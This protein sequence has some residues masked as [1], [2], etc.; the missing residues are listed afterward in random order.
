MDDTIITREGLRRLSDELER[1]KTE[2]R[3]SIAERLARAVASEANRDEN[4]ELLEAR[5]EQGLLE[6]RIAVLEE[7]LRSAL[8]VE[9]Q[10]GNGR[11]DVGERVRIR[12]LSTGERL[13]LELVGPF[14]S[15]PAAGPISIASPVGKAIVGRR[16]GE[17]ADVDTPR[18]RLQYKIVK[19]E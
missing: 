18:G 11:I 5:E 16:R 10:P 12:D 8:L 7:R 9:P 1:M 19:A 6:Q 13:D 2:G 3:R 14:E 4:A 15:D 17:I